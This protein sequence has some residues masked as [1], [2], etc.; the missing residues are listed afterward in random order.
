MQRFVNQLRG[1]RDAQLRVQCIPN[2]YSCSSVSTVKTFNN[3]Y[4]YVLNLSYKGMN[5]GGLAQNI[6]IK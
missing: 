3:L 6:L 4:C 5:S 1:F 2:A